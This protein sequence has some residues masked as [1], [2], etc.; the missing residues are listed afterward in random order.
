MKKKKKSWF[1]RGHFGFI[2]FR[3]NDIK[4]YILEIESKFQSDIKN[5]EKNYKTQK[6]GQT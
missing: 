1:Y 6:R 4:D 3:L 5:L 2:K